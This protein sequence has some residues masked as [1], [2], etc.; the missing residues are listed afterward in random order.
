MFEE[1]TL[2][3]GQVVGED[4]ANVGQQVAEA[5][6]AGG[7]ALA[8]EAEGLYLDPK[9]TALAALGYVREAARLQT[10]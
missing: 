7:H 6:C 5:A 9:Q 8:G 4:Q 2:L 10:G 1:G 3:V